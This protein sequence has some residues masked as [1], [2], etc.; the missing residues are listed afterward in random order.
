MQ[1]RTVCTVAKS[2]NVK[3]I[4]VTLTYDIENFSEIDHPPL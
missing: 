4:D 2:R 1:N 3:R